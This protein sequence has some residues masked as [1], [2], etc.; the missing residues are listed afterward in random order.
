MSFPVTDNRR[1]DPD[2][3][4]QCK[5]NRCIP[6]LWV[7]DFDN[8]CGDDSDEPAYQCRQR[9]CTNGW[10][11]CPGR[12]SYRCIPKWLFCDGKDDCRDNSDELP[13]F[14]PK[15][16]ETDDFQCPNNRCIPKSVDFR[17]S[18]RIFFGLLLIAGISNFAGDGCATSRTIAETKTIRTKVK[19]C[20]EARTDRA[21]NQNFSAVIPNAYRISGVA[22]T[23]TIAETVRTK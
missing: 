18:G 16:H 20:A 17:L 3:E 4:F 8:D 2:S 19:S 13:E 10:Q 15:C 5:N 12:T 14:C 7:C 21:R 6:K 23:M 9:N 1:C 22:I 11:R